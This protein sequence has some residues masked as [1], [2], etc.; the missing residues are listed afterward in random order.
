MT[1]E[2]RHIDAKV[3]AIVDFLV[4]SESKTENPPTTYEHKTDHSPRHRES[5]RSGSKSSSHRRHS[6]HSSSI[7]KDT[8]QTVHSFHRKVSQYKQQIKERDIQIEQLTDHLVE[9]KTTL[10][11][12]EEQLKTVVSQ[13][14][15]QSQIQIKAVVDRQT[16][17][18]K[19]LIKDKEDLTQRCTTL[20]K[21]LSDLTMQSQHQLQ[22]A[23]DRERQRA[24]QQ[25]SQLKQKLMGQSAQKRQREIAAAR[26][27][28]EASAV[29]KL[30]PRLAETLT[31]HHTEMEAVRLKGQNEVARVKLDAQ[32]Q[33]QRALSDSRREASV[34]LS[35]ALTR[36]RREHSEALRQARSQGDT[37]VSEASA[38]AAE[39][40]REAAGREGRL[41]AEFESEMSAVR[42]QSTRELEAETRR[43]RREVTELKER[44]ADELGSARRAF[45]S[46]GGKLKSR[47]KQLAV[48][49]WD[50][51]RLEAER[52]LRGERDR[53]LHELAVRVDTEKRAEIDSI[54][55][56]HA[57][58]LKQCEE[59][60]N[61]RVVESQGLTD[62]SKERVR[63]L[64]ERLALAHETISR[65]DREMEALRED[66][67]QTQKAAEVDQS[68]YTRLE[69]AHS[70]ACSRFEGQM[71]N[72]HM[73]N[74]DIRALA[75]RALRSKD[76]RRSEELTQ[77]HGQINKVLRGKDEC[78]A[79]M[80]RRLDSR[81]EELAQLQLFLGDV[82]LDSL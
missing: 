2:S 81:E 64:E 66:L 46:A 26:A 3:A 53:L 5:R 16:K 32:E 7:L 80:S 29:A 73:S 9:A 28:G 23:I 6:D 13:S 68:N 48:R 45:E 51:H 76:R 50:Q 20:A 52:E 67:F 37:V 47:Y 63:S 77:L 60:A 57:L 72:A 36:L 33:L 8:K 55:S 40:A 65:R 74:E 54:R 1:D 27:E 35:E 42:R 30:Q 62:E 22:T 18:A 70:S 49:L 58:K 19:Q 69:L 61:A 43:H 41:R 44:H 38:R 11:L 17:F 21:Q 78:I 12:Q 82:T 56:E 10:K 75:V 59:E 79:D 14:Q 39:A 4:E 24:Q 71:A 15:T 31:K 25:L 34:Q